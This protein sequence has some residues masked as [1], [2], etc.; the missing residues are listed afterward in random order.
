ME[1][2]AIGHGKLQS[3][4]ARKIKA[5]NFPPEPS[6]GNVTLPTWIWASETHIRL[7]TY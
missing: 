6:E 7:L 3:M 2:G 4:E 1:E 5:V